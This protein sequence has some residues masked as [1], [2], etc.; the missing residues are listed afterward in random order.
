MK[1]IYIAL[2]P[3]RKYH[4]KTSKGTLC[5]LENG[6]R[7]NYRF[8]TTNEKPK[9]RKLCDICNAL[10]H[11]KPKASFYE[12]HFMYDKQVDFELPTELPQIE[13]TLPI[14]YNG[15]LPPW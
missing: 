6:I 5:K 3:K 9:N 15:E 10:N 7:L 4:I 13:V 12:L 1:Y 11:R 2:K 14:Y 8:V